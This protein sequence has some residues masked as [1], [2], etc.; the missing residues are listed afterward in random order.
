MGRR[1]KQQQFGHTDAQR[2]PRRGRRFA[3]EKGLQHRIYAAQPPQNRRR[4]AMRRC[5]IPRFKPRG[6]GF[7]CLFQGP[8]AFQHGIQHIACGAPC[9]QAGRAPWPGWGFIHAAFMA[10]TLHS[11]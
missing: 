3:A 7:E 9:G 8:M 5:A 10:P 6:Q 2:V 11:C 1:A 4:N